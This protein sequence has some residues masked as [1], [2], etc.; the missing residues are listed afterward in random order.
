MDYI[1][2][3]RE[4][5]VSNFLFGEPGGLNDDTSFLEDGIIDSTGILELVVFLETTFK[6]DIENGELLPEN[7]GSIRQAAAFVE[8]KLEVSADKPSDAAPRVAAA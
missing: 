3:V 8:R 7:L 6:I 2:R 4:F 5:V 1:S